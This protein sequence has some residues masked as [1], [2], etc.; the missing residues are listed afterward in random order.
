MP[1][2]SVDG[3]T[4]FI[5]FDLDT[6]TDDEAIALE[7]AFAIPWLQFLNG[8][9]T[10][11]IRS[12]KALVWLAQRR[13]QPELK[14]SDVSYEVAKFQVRGVEESPLPEGDEP[15]EPAT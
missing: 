4:T 10:G 6:V 14:P 3:G 15:S 7:D 12:Q 5:T 9:N 2:L 13:E 11:S 1:E 8:L